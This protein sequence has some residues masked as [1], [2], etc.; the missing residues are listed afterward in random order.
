MGLAGPE[1]KE[2]VTD[3][4]NVSSVGPAGLLLG[5]TLDGGTAL[6]A[7][8]EDIGGGETVDQ[9]GGCCSPGPHPMGP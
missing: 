4:G 3:T 6:P 8:A 7:E 1:L 9:N 5:S 2:G